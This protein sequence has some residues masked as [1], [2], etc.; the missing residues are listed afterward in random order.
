MKWTTGCSILLLIISFNVRIGAAQSGGFLEPADISLVEDSLTIVE[1]GS[2][3]YVMGELQNSS[4]A[5]ARIFNV[6]VVGFDPAGEIVFVARPTPSYKSWCSEYY[7][8]G[9]VVPNDVAFF[10]VMLGSEQAEIDRFS[11]FARGTELTTIP[12][13]L[14]I[15]ISSPLEPD[16]GP[17]GTYLRGSLLNTGDE[18][19]VGL[20]ATAVFRGSDGELVDVSVF[21]VPGERIGGYLGGLRAGASVEFSAY[22]SLPGDEFESW[23]VWINGIPYRGRDFR[24]AVAGIAH[25]AG[26]EGADWRSSL[27]V[28]NRS[29]ADGHLRLRFFSE[30]DVVERERVV[31][32]TMSVHWD[33]VVRSLFE[34]TG[35]SA[36]F[37]RIDAD[38]PLTVTGRTAHEGEGG[39]YGQLLPTVTPD[40]TWEALEGGI[41]TPLRSGEF[42]RTNIG[43]VNFSDHSCEVRVQ[44]MD[45]DGNL[46]SDLGPIDIE[47]DSWKQINDVVP[48]TLAIGSAIV[49]EPDRCAL[50]TY[51]SVIDRTSHDPT[52]IAIDP[53][54]SIYI[55]PLRPGGAIS[56]VFWSQ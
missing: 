5:Q 43:F 2:L 20:N 46:V 28:T 51:A 30:Q 39:S 35:Q 34:V 16:P 1:A 12:N 36:G 40:T 19:I 4:E 38:V 25:R 31:A 7:Y 24:Y 6:A 13:V 26:Y 10:R 3:T 49:G 33:D 45:L 32:D 42:F 56:G 41:L 21:P 9:C 23:E 14:P 54:I 47:A 29:G 44:I 15:E 18:D 37:V 22:T 17:Y 52:T 8:E 53:E 55:G 50:W 27:T 11:V 48:P